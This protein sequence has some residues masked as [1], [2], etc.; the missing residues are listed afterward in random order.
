[1]ATQGQA[2]PSWASSSASASCHPRGI[3]TGELL[4]QACVLERPLWGRRGGG[5]EQGRVEEGRPVG[6][7]AG[8]D[9][10]GLTREISQEK[11]PVWA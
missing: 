3:L 6:G 2:E 1:M 5:M 4:G 11:W 7:V 8:S 9:R 10:M